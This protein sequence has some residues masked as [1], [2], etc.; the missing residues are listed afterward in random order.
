VGEQAG[1]GRLRVVGGAQVCER[2][3]ARRPA[4]AWGGAGQREGGGDMAGSRL[5]CETARGVAGGSGG[6]TG[7]GT[8]SVHGLGGSGYPPS[9][10]HARVGF[11]VLVVGPATRPLPLHPPRTLT[12]TLLVAGGTFAPAPPSPGVAFGARER[13]GV[14]TRGV[15]VPADSVSANGRAGRAHTIFFVAASWGRRGAAVI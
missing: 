15:N 8:A 13:G 1:S 5:V 14:W 2:V 6:S 12:V 10:V 4:R 11:H 7:A 3:V 9:P